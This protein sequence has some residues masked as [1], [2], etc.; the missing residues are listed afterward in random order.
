M[1]RIGGDSLIREIPF[2]GEEALADEAAV[3]DLLAMQEVDLSA[4]GANFSAQEFIEAVNSELPPVPSG[5]VSFENWTGRVAK[6]RRQEFLDFQEAERSKKRRSDVDVELDWLQRNR[7]FNGEPPFANESWEEYQA[8]MYEGWR[9]KNEERRRMRRARY[10]DSPYSAVGAIPGG[11]VRSAAAGNPVEV[12]A[13]VSGAAAE[14]PAGVVDVEMS[15][16][17]DTD[18]VANRK[19]KA[20]TPS[21]ATRALI[22]YSRKWKAWRQREDVK[23]VQDPLYHTG[24]LGPEFIP[25]SAEDDY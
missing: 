12:E 16:V 18:F 2:P 24:T 14:P 1:C 11:R 3:E 22:D 21:A 5:E 8:R 6:R 25:P 17:D 10:L 13:A 9:I 4:L 20:Y 23:S 15:M 7:L 19:Q